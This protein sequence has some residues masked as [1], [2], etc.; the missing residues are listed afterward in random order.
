M[1]GSV[2]ALEV[3]C[4][5]TRLKD[6]WMS[7]DYDRLSCH[8]KGTARDF[9]ERLQSGGRSPPCSTRGNVSWEDDQSIIVCK[10]QLISTLRRL[11]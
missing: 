6:I 10:G 4:V 7:G 8:I 5:K 9:F 11:P 2:I 3:E 1:S